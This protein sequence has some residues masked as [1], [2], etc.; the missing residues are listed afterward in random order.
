MNDEVKE[1]EERWGR[2]FNIVLGEGYLEV[3]DQAIKDINILLSEITLLESQKEELERELSRIRLGMGDDYGDDPVKVIDV[4]RARI[5]ELENRLTI[6]ILENAKGALVLSDADE[7]IKELEKGIEEVL[8]GTLPYLGEQR[9]KK[10][11][12]KK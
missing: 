9:L 11:V 5:K 7:R 2:G 12:E 6:K 3:T 4:L 8:D 1:I 10:L